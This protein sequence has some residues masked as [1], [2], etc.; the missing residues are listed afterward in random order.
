MQSR[1]FNKFCKNFV[2]MLLKTEENFEKKNSNLR[3]RL[4]MRNCK[5]I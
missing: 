4:Q 5:N 2:E 1:N 3:K